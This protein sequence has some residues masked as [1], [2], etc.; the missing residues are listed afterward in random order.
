MI[1]IREIAWF[2]LLFWSALAQA[3]TGTLKTG[4]LSARWAPDLGLLLRDTEFIEAQS[5]VEDALHIWGK[6]V[7][8]T[9]TTEDTAI[10]LH[11]LASK[12]GAAQNENP[13][14]RKPTERMVS[15]FVL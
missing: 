14:S 6:F 4:M 12:T 13:E 15:T 3:L 7:E 1:G 10:D 11:D 5:R 9:R 2:M 8:R